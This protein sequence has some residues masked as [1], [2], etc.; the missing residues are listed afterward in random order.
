MFSLI[1]K[2]LNTLSNS[3]QIS[4][5]NNFTKLNINIIPTSKIS[6][7]SAL[8][9]HFYVML[10]HLFKQCTK[11]APVRFKCVNRY[12]YLFSFYEFLCYFEMKKPNAPKSLSQS[13][14]KD[15]VHWVGWYNNIP[16]LKYLELYK[17]FSPRCC[18]QTSI[19]SGSM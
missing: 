14:Q 10:Y 6:V 2:V 1:C 8:S 3:H 13:I 12:A 11:W 15:L 19:Y 9:L 16:R 5:S 17:L 18:F 7:V 4:I